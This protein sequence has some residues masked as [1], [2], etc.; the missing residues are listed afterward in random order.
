MH[1][2]AVKFN[3]ER[4]SLRIERKLLEEKKLRRRSNISKSGKS[5]DIFKPK[6]KSGRESHSSGSETRR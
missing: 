6:D 1:Q 4:E 3:A 2:E 5:L